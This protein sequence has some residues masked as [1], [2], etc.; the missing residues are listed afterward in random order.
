[1]FKKIV[2]AVLALTVVGAAGAAIAY[3]STPEDAAASPSPLAVNVNNAQGKGNPASQSP[4]AGQTSNGVP[5]AGFPA[6]DGMEGDPWE[7]SGEIVSLDDFGMELSTTSGETVYVELGP[8][9]YWQ[10]QDVALQVGQ[11]VT[12]N[13]SINEGM[14]HA[15]QVRLENGETLRLRSE[16]GQPLW[17]G[18]A[19]NGYNGSADGTHQPEP[20]AQVD[21][22]VTYQ[23]TLMSYQGSMMS[24][25]T[26]D[27]QLIA[28]QVGRPSFFA[29]QDVTFQVGDEI[30]VTGFYE[31]DQFVA[32]D[33]TKV[34]T[35]ERVMLRDPNGRPLW[36]GPGNGNGN[37]GNGGQHGGTQQP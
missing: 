2:I 20:Q 30:I 21:E 35:G 17:S 22:W 11:T 12:V 7:A 36:A 19:S 14:I 34:A 5:Q 31:N 4:N 37:G 15:A 26:D 32:G 24:L 10:E 18:G 1:M 25:G 27:G 3:N 23:G 29:S 6:A 28:F 9:T 8:P 13:G 16:T 33:I